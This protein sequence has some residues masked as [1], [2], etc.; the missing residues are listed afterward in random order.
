MAAIAISRQAFVLALSL[1]IGIPCVLLL[2]SHIAPLI[3]TAGNNVVPYQGE[4][5]LLDYAWGLVWAMVLWAGIAFWPAS[6]ADRKALLILWGAR[7]IMALGLSLAYEYKYGLDIDGHFGWAIARTITWDGLS[8]GNG[9][10]NVRRLVWLHTHLI[11]NSYHGAKVG[12]A[13]IGLISIFVFYRAAVLFMR[14]E[15]NRLLYFVGLFPSVLFWSCILGKD[16]IVLLGMSLYCYGVI[17]AYRFGRYKYFLFVLVGIAVMALIRLWLVPICIVPYLAMHIRISR[18][19]LSRILLAAVS[20]SVLFLALWHLRNS[21]RLETM[22]DLL[23]FRTY[24]TTAFEGGGSSLTMSEISGIGTTV[25]ALPLAIFTALFRPLP[26]EVANIF[27]FLSGLDNLILLAL[28]FR[29]V[30]RIRIR[31]LFDPVILWAVLVILIWASLYGMVTYNF[32]SLVRYKLQ[33]LPIQIG[34][35]LYL[36]RSRKAAMHRSW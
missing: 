15:D 10:L 20:T 2:A 30:I 19:V 29:A 35:L 12:F 11:P 13:Y 21:W 34:L 28:S 23:G 1:A 17:G 33:I 5:I 9:S 3:I 8:F 4:N 25:L 26:M 7:I 14:R 32:G 24:A 22:N 6:K 31:E 27:G 18:Q 16:P 36:G